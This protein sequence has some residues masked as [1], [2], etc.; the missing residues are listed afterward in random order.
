M[1]AKEVIN[2]V[3]QLLQAHR[4]DLVCKECGKRFD[5]HRRVGNRN[6]WVGGLWPIHVFEASDA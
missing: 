5:E 3:E 6:I 2:E 1:D 4:P